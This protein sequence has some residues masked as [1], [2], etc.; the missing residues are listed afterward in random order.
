GLDDVVGHQAT[1]VMLISNLVSNSLKFIAPG[2]QPQIRIWGE[3][4]DDTIRLNVQDNGI[5]INPAD[6]KRLFTAFQRLHGKQDYPGTGLGL[7][8]VRVGA[9]RMGGRVGVESEPGKGSLFWVELKADRG[10]PPD[11]LG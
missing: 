8:L 6:L 5:G 7:A 9:E 2:V 10:V 4:R 1:V 11:G 3:R